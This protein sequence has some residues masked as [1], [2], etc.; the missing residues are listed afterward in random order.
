[1]FA[2]NDWFASAASLRPRPLHYGELRPYFLGVPEETVRHTYVCTTRYY[3]NF[4]HREGQVHMYTSPYPGL[5]IARRSED[6]STDTLY[7]DRPA[8]GGFTCVQIFAGA[9]SYYITAHEC[10]TDGEFAS[11]LEDEIRSHGAMNRLISDRAKAEISKKV[12][13]ILRKYIID[14]HQSEPYHQNQNPV[15]RHIQD[16]KRYANYVL[17]YSGAPGES[18]VLVIRY[19]I[20]IMNRTARNVLAWR[21]PYEKLHGQTPDISI[22]TK[23]QFWEPVL[24]YNHETS[25]PSTA[26]KILVRFVGFSETVGNAGCYMVWNENTGQVL[27]RSLLFR[28]D[29]RQREIHGV[30]PFPPRPDSGEPDDVPVDSAIKSRRSSDGTESSPI[31]IGI[32]NM[33]NRTFLLPPEEDGTRRRA[34]IT[35]IVEDF[36]GQLDSN[37]SRV[38]FKAKVGENK[39]DELVEYND[40]MELINEQAPLDDGTWRFRKILDHRRPK[41]KREK[42]QVL[43]EW[44]SGERTWEPISSIYTGDKY[45]LAEYARDNGL[46]DEWESP[47]MK[48]K[49][50]AKNSKK[51]LRLVN[52]AKLKSYKNTPVYKNGHKVPRNH[53]QAMEL[54]RINGNTKWADAERL[55]KD[56]LFEYETFDDRG[57]RSTSA[58]PRGYKKIN[59]HF[60]YDVKHDGRYKARVVAGGHLTE[61]PVES[62]YSG[63]VSMRGIRIVTFIAELNNLEVWQTDIGNAYLEAYT[64]EK[65]YVIAGPEFGELNGHIFVIRKALYGLKTSSIRWHE[66]FSD[67]LRGMGFVPSLAEPDIWMR[68]RGDHYEYIATYVDD[69]TIASRDPLSIIDDLEALFKLKGTGEIDV[70][71]GC[72]YFRDEHSRLCYSPKNYLKKMENLYKELFKE[73]PKY[74]A[75]PLEENDHPELDESD[76]LNEEDTRIYQSLIGSAQWVIQLGRFDIAVHVMTLSSFRAQP[77]QGHLDRIKRV[78][79]YLAKMKGS[80]IRIRTAMPDISDAAIER[81]DWSRTVYA[82]AKEETPH[83]MPAPKGMPVRLIT[84]ADSNLCHNILDGKAV[85]GILHFVNQ[86][87]FDWFSKKQ[88]TAETATFG[89]EELAGRTA[90]EQCRA[91]RLTF[92]YLGVPIE[93]PTLVLGDNKS[94]VD[95]ATI[96]HRR[97]AK[98]HLMLSW[99]YVREAIA[100]GKYEYLHIPGVINPADILSKHWAYR[101]VWIML[102]T[103]LFWHGDTVELIEQ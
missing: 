37:P 49:A 3:S 100:T 26:N 34:R 69:L 86:T 97:L 8:W 61:T 47:R 87:P 101:N 72:N 82:G 46:L 1:M 83:N 6:V 52:Q 74:Y 32:E 20:Y 22:M 58:P 28:T 63:V 4:S 14:A 42:W 30:T 51:L 66:R 56:Q 94:V 76:F 103:I 93:G 54:D 70:L 45:V 7:A 67:V 27:H 39:F 2:D 9:E 40:L 17:T 55:E 78:I 96:P 77:R 98:R 48:L 68:D 16:V 79:G 23:F 18:W 50:A 44:E 21:T 29:K 85:T 89:A 65:V 53:Q 92:L 64:T 15:E 73:P 71:L 38:K 13:D 12:E 57:H 10:R 24:I 11:T 88:A 102:K 90:I 25:F 81:Y 19:V 80:A 60:V 75:S 5:G 43:I 84:Y 95:G 91:N 99:H 59:L 31:P 35:E 33:L 36:S 62:I 41:S